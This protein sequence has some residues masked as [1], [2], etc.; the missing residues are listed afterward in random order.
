M[1]ASLRKDVNCF[2]VG[3]DSDYASAFGVTGLLVPGG[4]AGSENQ[5]KHPPWILVSY[6]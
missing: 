2:N 3:V 6:E 5:I 1:E 4:R